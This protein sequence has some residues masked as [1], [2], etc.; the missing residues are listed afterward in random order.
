M[1]LPT[2]ADLLARAKR[3]DRVAF[4]QLAAPHLEPLRW[5]C[6]AVLKDDDLAKETSL[7]ALERAWRKLDQCR[8]DFWPWLKSIGYHLSL[9]TIKL[10][11]YRLTEPLPDE[12]ASQ[13]ITFEDDLVLQLD[14]DAAIALLPEHYQA[15]LRLRYY[16]KLE[17]SEVAEI[18]RITSMAARKLH[19]RAILSLRLLLRPD[20][21]YNAPSWTT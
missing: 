5:V 16:A 21:G 20:D 11:E 8:G 2:E 1:E 14:F 13:A 19:E 3:G 9:D 10:A 17:W 7:A 6:W 18:M 12:W 4:D 15:V